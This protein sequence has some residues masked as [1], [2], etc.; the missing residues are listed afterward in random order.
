MKLL[1]I[2]LTFIAAIV[3]GYLIINDFN[4]D[5][6]SFSNYLINALFIVLLSCLVLI[7]IVY[8][9]SVKRRKN[10]KDIMT[11]RQYYQYKSIR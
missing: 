2:F 8:S 7:G 9:I 4:F 3:G 5:N 11:I 10:S 1:Y 6:T